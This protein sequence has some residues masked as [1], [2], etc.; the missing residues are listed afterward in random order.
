MNVI[1]T[2]FIVIAVLILLYFGLGI[3]QPMMDDAE[4][5]VGNDTALSDSLNTSI[6]LT[7]PSFT[8]MG[9][10]VWILVLVFV[11]GALLLLIKIL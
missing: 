4:A 1:S 5:N 7:A 6:E 8:I 3:I 10:M 11:I 9:G 2:V